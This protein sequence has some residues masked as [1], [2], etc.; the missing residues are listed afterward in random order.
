MNYLAQVNIGD[1]FGSPFGQT[2]GKTLGDLVSLVLT[3]A[4]IIA[5]VITLFMFVLGGFSML[6]GAGQDNPERAAKGRQAATWG[7]IG[8]G[9]VFGAYWIIRIIEAIV[10]EKF[11]TAPA[12]L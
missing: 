5:G 10:G 7:A 2:G 8:F 9:V 6:V 3:S 4:I 1:K 12:I 11:I